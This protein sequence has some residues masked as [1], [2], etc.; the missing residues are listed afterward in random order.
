MGTIFKI[1]KSLFY[2]IAFLFIG[3]CSQDQINFGE[4][5]TLDCVRQNA[6]GTIPGNL[7]VIGSIIQ[8]DEYL[9]FTKKLT[10][11]GI[12]LIARD[13]VSDVFM[14]KVG[15]TVGEMF[16]IH[17]ETDTLNKVKLLKNL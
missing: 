2:L 14:M 12:T 16:L 4:K 10:V 7:Y 17:E 5:V 3:S 13:G 6:S 9:P 11:C 15:Q 1:G 8:T